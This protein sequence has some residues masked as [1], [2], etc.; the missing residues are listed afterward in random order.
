MAAELLGNGRPLF[1]QH[2][3]AL[4]FLIPFT[5][6][7]SPA[8]RE[9]CSWLRFL[10]C[11]LGLRQP[12]WSQ[13]FQPQTQICRERSFRTAVYTHT[14][15]W[16]NKSCIKGDHKANASFKAKVPKILCGR[17]IF[18]NVQMRKLSQRI[19]NP[20]K[21]DHI[22]GEGTQN[23]LFTFK[24]SSVLPLNHTDKIKLSLHDG[25]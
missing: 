6:A 5:H 12:S 8:Q 14:L 22:A 7:V 10:L 15:Q 3:G 20:T 16:Q 25:F 24:H 13:H 19:N 18:P 2:L 1:A 23:H 9:V 4:A 11:L 21:S 17:A